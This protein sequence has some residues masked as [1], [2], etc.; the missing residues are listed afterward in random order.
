MLPLVSVVIPCRNEEKFIGR[1]LDS[2]I[3]QDYPKQNLE[4]L[5]V[6][7]M[8]EDRTKEIVEE[9][10]KKYPF[11]KPLENPKKYTNFAFNIGVK[12][13]K[14]EIIMIMGAHATYQQN[15]VSKCLKYLNE[16]NADNVG[17]IWKI[18]PGENSVIAKAIAL[19]SSSIFGA[20]DA[21][22]RRGYSRGIKWVDT[23]FGGCYK[24]EVFNKIG[25]FNENLF[26]SQDMDLNLRLKKAGGKI[27]LVP[28]IVTYYYSQPTMEGFLKHNFGDGIWVTY[29][30]KFGI[31]AFSWRHMIPLVFVAS[32]ILSLF[33]SLFFWPARFIFYLILGGYIL[34]TLFFSIKISLKKG[35]KYLLVMPVVFA[36]RHLAYGLGSIFGLLKI[37]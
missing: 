33:L 9:Y 13:S 32:L 18:V 31:R 6:N 34:L 7:G 8:S 37:L 30:L 28:S 26:R 22:Y 23:V 10:R 35:F 29:P 14:G 24:K 5:V 36:I 15:Y 1:C 25:L 19:A 12:E 20:G 16:Y 3:Q 4:I 27:L 17:G 2:I 11:I 21:Y